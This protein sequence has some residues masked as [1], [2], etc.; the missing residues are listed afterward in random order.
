MA[1]GS[2]V[3][4]KAFLMFSS[5]RS[6]EEQNLVHPTCNQGKGA[7][8]ILRHEG[9]GVL[10]GWPSLLGEKTQASREQK[11]SLQP[12][13]KLGAQICSLGWFG[14]PLGGRGRTDF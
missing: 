11:Q 4:F 5:S 1:L 3:S 8:N 14:D 12:C 9:A 2:E 13:P 7:V 10:A 6:D